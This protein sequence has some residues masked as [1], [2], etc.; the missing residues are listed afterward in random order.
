MALEELILEL[1]RIGCIRF[2]EFRL[3]SGM[4][5]PIYIDLRILASHPSVLRL[6]ARELAA[7]VSKLKFDRIAAVPYAG[8]PI[9]TALSLE[10][11]KPMIY[12]RREQKSYGTAQLIE[13]IWS[14]GET[15]VV[16]DDLI[17]T[18]ESKFEVIRP[19]ERAGLEVRDVV[20]VIDREQG[21][22]EALERGGYRL[23]ALLKLSELLECLERSG[24][25]SSEQREKV[26]GFIK[27]ARV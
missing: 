6:V 9:G 16:V 19:L 8:L 5:S 11:E 14:K 2:G 25:I 27:S 3:K 22:G 17:T 24:K 7:V 26:L 13:G 20:V 15:A 1:H 23:H 12:P 18:G 21:G 4:V 10:T